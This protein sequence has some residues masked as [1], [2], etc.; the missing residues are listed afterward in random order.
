MFWGSRTK[1]VAI[2]SEL[3]TGSSY[4]LLYSI[5]VDLKVF[6]GLWTKK[7]A[8]KNEIFT[9]SNSFPFYSYEVDRNILG[10][11]VVAI[12]FYIQFC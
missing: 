6:S 4:F 2:E 10:S 12:H 9:G 5:G 8:I 3:F 7:D 11:E 1:K